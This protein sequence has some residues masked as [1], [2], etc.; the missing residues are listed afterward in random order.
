MEIFWI[1]N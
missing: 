1:G